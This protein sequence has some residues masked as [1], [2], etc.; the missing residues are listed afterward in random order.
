MLSFTGRARAHVHVAR[1]KGMSGAL[2][3]V[4]QVRHDSVP[5]AHAACHLTA[6]P[7]P[8]GTIPKTIEEV[9]PV[10]LVQCICS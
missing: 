6:L 8:K 7:W 4:L 3:E 5:L 9:R 1:G 10:Y 2:L